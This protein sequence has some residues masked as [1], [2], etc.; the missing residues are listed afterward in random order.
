MPNQMKSP[1][2]DSFFFVDDLTNEKA[3][4]IISEYIDM[5]YP[6]I[7]DGVIDQEFEAHSISRWVCYEILNR[8]M[9]DSSRMGF[10]GMD[11]PIG[12]IEWF[13]YE[14]EAAE[15]NSAAERPKEVYEIAAGVG[16][17]LLALFI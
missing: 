6:E 2:E 16:E 4:E 17:E 12:T 5:N 14:M 11:D 13:V 10:D 1:N 7:S 9:D 3:I 8:L 15:M